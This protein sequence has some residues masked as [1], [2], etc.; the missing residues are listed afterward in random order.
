MTE[1]GNEMHFFVSIS[2]ISTQKVKMRTMT[3]FNC[4]LNLG[5]QKVVDQ[6]KDI[7]YLI[8]WV[9]LINQ[10]IKSKKAKLLIRS[11]LFLALVIILNRKNKRLMK[12]LK[13]QPTR[14]KI[15]VDK[16]WI[17]LRQEKCFQDMQI[18]IHEIRKEESG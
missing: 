11:S 9:K 8:C 2:T 18:R 10:E 6:Q 5:C 14:V 3:E 15:D 1:A 7:T 12:L 17:E 13:W 16:T 4:I